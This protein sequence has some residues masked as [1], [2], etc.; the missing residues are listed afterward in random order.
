MSTARSATISTSVTVMLMCGTNSPCRALADRPERQHRVDERGHERAERELRAPVADEVAQHA[1]AEL[2]GGQGQ[3]HDHDREDHADDR[4]D[5]R[6]DRGQDLPRGVGRPAD[7][8]AGHA[9]VAVVGGP[10]QRVGAGEQQRRRTS[11]STA[12][13]SHRLVR[14]TSLRHSEPR[15]SLRITA[16]PPVQACS[17]ERPPAGPVRTPT[18]LP[19]SP[20]DVNITHR[21]TGRESSPRRPGRAAASGRPAAT[22]T[23]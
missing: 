18:R 3:R 5:G 23:A 21:R 20:D 17:L 19:G 6:G 15:S 7:R 9:E 12:G 2:G 22:V 1:G 8:P 11:T 13:T 16:P 14:S 10:V 4:D